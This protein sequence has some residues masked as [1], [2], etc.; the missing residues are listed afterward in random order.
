MSVLDLNQLAEVTFN[1]A[2]N[3][4]LTKLAQENNTT[5]RDVLPW[6]AAAAAAPVMVNAGSMAGQS[7]AG[8]VAPVLDYM[9]STPSKDLQGYINKTL[10]NRVVPYHTGAIGGALAGLIGAYA[11]KE[12]LT[13]KN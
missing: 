1:N 3:S 13:K 5:M 12:Y 8:K 2:F 6:L 11:L 7:M 9:S 4:E 10:G